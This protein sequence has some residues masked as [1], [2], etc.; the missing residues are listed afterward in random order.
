MEN[1]PTW[2]CNEWGVPYPIYYV[3]AWLAITSVYFGPWSIF[4]K[5]YFKVKSAKFR[6]WIVPWL[7]FLGYCIYLAFLAVIFIGFENPFAQLIA[8]PCL[9]FFMCMGYLSPVIVLAIIITV[10]KLLSLGD[11]ANSS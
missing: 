1:Y 10:F 5:K 11:E 4:S 9:Y 7:S 3:I 2:F 8:F 6:D